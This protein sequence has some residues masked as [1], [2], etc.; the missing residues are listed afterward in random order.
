MFASAFMNFPKQ[1]MLLRSLMSIP[2][3]RKFW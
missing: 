2:N 1:R 3:C